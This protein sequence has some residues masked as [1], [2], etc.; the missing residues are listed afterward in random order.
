MTYFTQV[1]TGLRDYCLHE[2]QLAGVG[3]FF[4]EI[5]TVKTFRNE[6]SLRSVTSHTVTNSFCSNDYILTSLM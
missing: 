3:I 6:Y 1:D 2:I 4:L 5:I